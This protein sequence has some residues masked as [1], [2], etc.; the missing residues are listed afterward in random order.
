[1]EKFTKFLCLNLAV[2]ALCRSFLLPLGAV[3]ET[4]H[5]KG[6][7]FV[8]SEDDTYIYGSGNIT[9][10]AGG[11]QVKGDVLYMSVLD[12]SGVIYGDVRLTTIE[13]KKGPL[14]AGGKKKGTEKKYDAI[15]FRGI[16]PRWLTVSYGDEMEITGDKDLKPLFLNFVKHT[17]DVLKQAS[18]YFEF[19][20]CRIDKK[21][22]IKAK[23][24]ITYAM[25]LPTVPLKRFTIRR[26]SYPDKTLV[27]FR[28]VGYSGVDGLSVAFRLRMREKFAKGDYNIKLYERQLFGLEEP[29]RGVLLSG[30]NRVL[31]KKTELLGISALANSGDQS[32]NIRLK[33]QKDFKFLSY[34]LSQH[35]SGQ[36][37]RPAFFEFSSQVTV[38]PLKLIVPSFQFTHDWKKSYSYRLSTPLNLW[39]PLGL[40]ISWQRRII[41]GDYRS[42]T[43]DLSASLNFNAP[44][45]TLTSNYN[46]SKN[47]LE[48]AVRKNFSVNMRLKPLRFLMDNISLD[49][50]SFYMFSEIPIGEGTKE[51][52]SPGV[53]IALRSTGASLPLGFALVPAFTF[54]HLW[55][56]QE[57]DFTDFNYSLALQQEIGIFRGSIQYALASRYRA[58]N[59]W[60]EGSNRQN[61]N[62]NLELFKEDKYSFLLR[63]YFN[64]NLAL[65]NISFTGQLDLP[66]DVRLSS[67]LL[68][69]YRENRFQTL[70]VFIEKTL[71]KT[72]KI[73]GGYSLALKR[74]FIKFL[75]L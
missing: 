66:F 37:N 15:Y 38:K 39:K 63:F 51:R 21:R 17:P 10:N 56:N 29:K 40:N 68:Y 70:E 64:D 43:S 20:E 6:D 12:L 60:I 42:D 46:F 4:L 54:N 53:N 13:S 32:F 3:K 45:F 1:M 24:V 5:F 65:E 25:G 59:F 55:D 23:I 18:L 41:K 73:Q 27:A 28:N 26:G 36:K 35:M 7:Y 49:I 75:T 52:I 19:K 62:L 67:F 2:L 58:R 22:K 71:R 33:H 69:Y 57:E 74:F 72:I 11:F 14:A 61:L 47:L 48:A 9:L 30:R 16:P 31:L 34:T 44:F 8:Y 50:S